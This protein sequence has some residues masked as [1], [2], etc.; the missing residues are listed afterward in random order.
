ML[1][2]PTDTGLRNILGGITVPFG[3]SGLTPLSRYA[4]F[5]VCIAVVLVNRV[6]LATS[7]FK[8]EDQDGREYCKPSLGPD[9]SI[10]KKIL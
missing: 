7:H 8:T 10:I 2:Q 5:D 6:D 3:K 9:V 4:V 1:E